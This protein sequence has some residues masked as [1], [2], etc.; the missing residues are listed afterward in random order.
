MFGNDAE[1]VDIGPRTMHAQ[2]I[3]SKGEDFSACR[4][5]GR[6]AQPTSKADFR[7]KLLHQCCDTAEYD[8]SVE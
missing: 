2:P 1:R 6:F 3:G 7:D 8:F 5:S 4:G